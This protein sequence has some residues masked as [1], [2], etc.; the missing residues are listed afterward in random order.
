MW[1]K[2]ETHSMS[3][4]TI[5]LCK[6]S[7]MLMM[8]QVPLRPH[9]ISVLRGGNCFREVLNDS[10]QT[11][12]DSFWV[13]PPSFHLLCDALQSM[14]FLDKTKGILIEEAVAMTL[15]I[16]A[17][18]RTMRVVTDRFQHFMQTVH[19]HFKNTVLAIRRL[20]RHIL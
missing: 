11:C 10:P 3:P 6:C 8:T 14:E 7:M 1:V 18:A 12:Y 15:F 13:R 19:H 20:G 4:I 16:F 17:H 9:H 5:F 2:E